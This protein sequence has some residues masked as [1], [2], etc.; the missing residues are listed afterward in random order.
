MLHNLSPI[1]LEEII[2]QVVRS[3]LEEF[4]NNISI[5]NPDELLTRTEAC[6]LLKINMTTLWS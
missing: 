5:L 3:Q 1:E 6:S 2:K 4:R